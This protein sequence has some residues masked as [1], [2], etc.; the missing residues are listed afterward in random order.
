MKYRSKFIH[1]KPTLIVRII[2]VS[3]FFLSSAIFIF[4][5]FN[6][7]AESN[8]GSALIKEGDGFMAK[9]NLNGFEKALAKYK[10]ALSK[11]P[12]NIDTMT[13]TA[14]ALVHIMRVKTNGNALKLDGSTQDDEKNKKIWK[15]YG[16]EAV[17]LSEKAFKERPND[18]FTL[19][20][21]A[22]SYMYY[23]SSFGILK[24]IFKGAAGQYKD[25]SYALIKNCPKLDDAVGDIYMGGFNIVA[26]WPMSDLDD[27]R[28]HY[29]NAL[30]LAPQSV[31]SH[32]YVGIVAIKD[33]K[34][35][36]AKKS[37]TFTVENPCTKGP[38]HDYCGFLKEQ[39]KKGLA[40][41]EKKIKK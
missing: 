39:A 33:E 4:S 8:A 37:F 16:E 34:Y 14:N 23:S 12:G 26:P 18:C 1:S 24:A 19:N 38:E 27:A 41:V 28:N 31:R 30:K 35:D 17:K 20:V 40:L 2:F 36:L 32:Y 22:E 13:K 6:L 21:Y 11:D 15:E 10:E 3:S 29:N 5:G 7:G 25:N 9:R